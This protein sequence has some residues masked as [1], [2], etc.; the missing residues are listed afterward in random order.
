MK[1]LIGTTAAIIG[2]MAAGS[3]AWGQRPTGT[4]ALGTVNTTKC[5]GGGAWTCTTQQKV[6][7]RDRLRGGKL[8]ILAIRRTTAP[9]IRGTVL[10]IGGHAGQE[11]W[12]GAPSLRGNGKIECR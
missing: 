10:A 3:A 9:V 7:R 8:A 2:L 6:A 4:L 5:I 12:D 11:W 1:T